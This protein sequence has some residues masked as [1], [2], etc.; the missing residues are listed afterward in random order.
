VV[1]RTHGGFDAVVLA[2]GAARRL[3]GIDKPAALVGGQPLLGRV[4]AAVSDAGRVIVV[5]PRRAAV[6]APYGVC[7][8]LEDPPGGGPLAA[9]AAGLP[10]VAAPLVAVLAADLPFLGASHL[11]ALRVAVGARDGALL[12]DPDGRDQLLAGVW[13]TGTLRA[14]LPAEPAG[15]SLRSV[16]GVLDAERVPAD[17]R[18]CLDCDTAD[19]LARA[20]AWSERAGNGAGTGRES[21]PE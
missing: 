18:T 13:R 7:W 20:R 5:G 4:L 21:S 11:A 6:D 19:E 14:A 12:V 2:G 16:L 10:L 3:G 15:R 9:L 1:S 8:V 17:P